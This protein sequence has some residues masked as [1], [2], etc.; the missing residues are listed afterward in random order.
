MAKK[1]PVKKKAVKK[2]A[3]KKVAKKKTTKKA[4]KKAAASADKPK[5]SRKKKEKVVR[6]ATI[7]VAPA[8]ASKKAA[9]TAAA[10]GRITPGAIVKRAAGPVR[11]ANERPKGI[12]IFRLETTKTRKRKVTHSK[13]DLAFYRKKLEEK[14]GELIALNPVTRPE[15]RSGEGDAEDIVDKAN[16]AYNQILSASISDSE[17]RLLEEVEAAIGRLDRGEFGICQHTGDPIPKERLRAVPW[18][19][20]CIESQELY[21]KGLLD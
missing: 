5:S 14:R 2:A 9:E 7:K 1:K 12:K 11:I 15:A 13:A 18:A 20:Y 4:A 16:H 10:V 17:H 6:K 21:E 3:K 8:A 19:R